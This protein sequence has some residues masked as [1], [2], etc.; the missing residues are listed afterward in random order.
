MSTRKSSFFY[1]TLIALASLV[2]GMVIASRLELTPSSLAGTLN[3]PATNSAPL[4]GVLDATTFRTIAHDQTPGVVSIWITEKVDVQDDMSDFFGFQMP[5]SHR[6]G[7]GGAGASPQPQQE[8]RTGAGSG[9]IIDK[10]GYI[11]TNNHVIENA[12]TIMVK[13]S[14]MGEFA[15]GLPAKVVGHDKLTDSALIQLTTLPKQPLT[16]VK[17]GDSAQ[18][19]AGDWVMAIGNPLLFSNSVTVGVVSAVGRVRGELNPMAGRD[20]EYIQ[21]D[22]AINKGNSG[23]PLLNIR[24]EVIGINTA[25]VNPNVGQTGNIGIG[26]AVPINTVRDV[27]PQLRAGKVVRGRIGVSVDKRPMTPEDAKAFGLSSAMGAFVKGVEDGAPAKAAGIEAGDVIVDFNGKPVKDSGDLV[28]MV[29]ATTPGT[30]V[31]VKLMRDGKTM[32]LSIKIGELNADTEPTETV[33]RTRPQPATV[34]PKDTGFGMSV[35][36]ISPR[37]SR[38]LPGGKGGAIVTDLDPSG[39]AYRSGI[40]PNDVILRIDGKDM[41]SVDDVTKALSAV[42][43]GQSVRVLVWQ[44]TANGSGGSEEALLL[45]KR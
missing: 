43:A 22:A 10:A 7:R 32:A 13:L 17:F 5:P 1:G 21:T 31:P 39:A 41:T 18:L 11:L 3:V 23:G 20:L 40:E 38:S 16:E 44:P 29:S 35:A 15:E 2:A 4:N 37:V 28:S 27:L 12:M 33:A 6:G 26:F 9:F 30:S 14:D 8:T 34:E 36:P 45:R 25:I 19:A 24:G 42:A